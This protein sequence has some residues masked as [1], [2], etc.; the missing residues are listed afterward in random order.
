MNQQYV[1]LVENS[2][3]EQ[4]E[5]NIEKLVKQ[6]QGLAG[7]N[8][9]PELADIIKRTVTPS[10]MAQFAK[11]KGYFEDGDIADKSIVEF[12]KE[13]K[14]KIGLPL[15]FEEYISPEEEAPE[16]EAP[17]E[18]GDEAPEEGGAEDDLGL[19]GDEEELQ[20]DVEVDP[21]LITPATTQN[22]MMLPQTGTPDM[23]GR[24]AKSQLQ[25]TCEYSTEMMDMI[26]DDEQLP[27]WVQAKL[28]KVADYI[29]AVKQYLEADQGLK[30]D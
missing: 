11:I 5:T 8:I 9:K 15:E 20:D 28:T 14:T 10:N 26:Q 12:D 2:L 16:E 17:E 7:F 27:S 30:R 3:T 23:E 13:Y 18:G 22:A 21:S 1:T 25:K 6:I 19:E 24:L 4:N 29:G